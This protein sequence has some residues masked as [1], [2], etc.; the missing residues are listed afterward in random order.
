MTF[1]LQADAVEIY[2]RVIVPLWF[3]NWAAALLELVPPQPG[4]AVLDVA[5]GTG[6]TTR[7]AKHR[8]GSDGQVDGLD[9]NAKMLD[10]AK[11]HAEVSGIRW[12]ECDICESHL[13]ANR[14]NIILSQQGYQYFTDQPKALKELYRLLVPGGK[15]AFSVWD[16]QSVYTEAV[17]SAIEKYISIDAANIQRRQRETPPVRELEGALSK[18]GYIDIRIERQELTIRVPL[19]PEFVPLHLTSMPIGPKFLELPKMKK[20]VNQGC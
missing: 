4:D 20:T 12:I 1:Q 8:V 13:P 11:S 2:E 18:A 10:R 3:E 5:C 9:V 7:L 15:L 19:A 16:G 6:V 17:C 14:Y